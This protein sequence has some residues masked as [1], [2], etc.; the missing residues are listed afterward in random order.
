MSKQIKLF[1]T[2]KSDFGGSLFTTRAERARHRPVAQRSSMHIVLRSSVATGKYAFTTEKNRKMVSEEICRFSK[3]HYVKV[4]SC[5]LVGNHIH[6]HIKLFKA[7]LYQPFIR[8]LTASIA[9][10]VSGASKKHTIKSIFGRK[11]W[12]YRPFSRIVSSYHEF[13]NLRDYIR[14][15]EW[16]GYGVKRPMARMLVA[17]GEW[18]DLS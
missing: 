6:L 18:L 13:L 10:K 5:A 11:F 9:L 14:V 2:Q 3:K 4:L 12:D 17:R 15:N 8:G 1:K 7:S 16:E